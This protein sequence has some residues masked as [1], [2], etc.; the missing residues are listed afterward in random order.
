M[1]DAIEE[2]IVAASCAISF[3]R[4]A[5]RQSGLAAGAE[6]E[7]RDWRGGHEREIE[8][9]GPTWMIEAAAPP[10]PSRYSLPSLAA[11][12]GLTIDAPDPGQHELAATADP[13]V[14]R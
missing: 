12:A 5:H 14:A 11:I 4:L 1:R 3:D 8:P 13:A 6:R 10:P 2:L 7:C 9:G